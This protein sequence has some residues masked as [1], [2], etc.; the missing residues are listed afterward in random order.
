MTRI[1]A[2]VICL[3][4]AAPA[5]GE[6]ARVSVRV[7]GADPGVGQVAGS[8]FA[9]KDDYL[10]RGVAQARVEVDGE[11]VAVLD[12]GPHPPG[13]YAVSV[14]WDEDSDGE[15][16]SGFMRIPKEKVGFSNNARGRF[17][18]AKWKDAHFTVD[19]APLELEISLTRAKD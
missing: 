11:G 12:F 19:D 1:T 14:Y 17:G 9:S 8:L 3:L 5:L 16:D 13:D 4:L 6:D 15:L 10:K 7:S 18:P 2:L